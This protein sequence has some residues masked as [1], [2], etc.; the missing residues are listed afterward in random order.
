MKTL[1]EIQ[2]DLSV[3]LLH[4]S[5]Q[6]DAVIRHIEQATA[7]YTRQFG[8]LLYG[9]SHRK[10]ELHTGTIESEAYLFHFEDATLR[11]DL[12]HNYDRASTT[13]NQFE[14]TLHD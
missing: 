9:E 13:L 3:A 8:K 1:K 10:L 4:L 5:D 11:A 6:R 14:L 12:V 2:L 7:R